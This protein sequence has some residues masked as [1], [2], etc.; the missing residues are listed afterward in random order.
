MR[1]NAVCVIRYFL[2]EYPLLYYLGF[3]NV[4]KLD[5]FNNKNLV[6]EY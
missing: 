6:K 1:R 2:I 5:N 4:E 3:E